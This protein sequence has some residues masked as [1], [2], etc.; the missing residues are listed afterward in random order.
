[1][2]EHF[3]LVLQIIIRTDESYLNQRTKKKT[4]EQFFAYFYV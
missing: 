2:I 3:D 1:M 4:V